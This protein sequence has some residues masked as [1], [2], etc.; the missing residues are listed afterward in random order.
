MPRSS[1]NMQYGQQGYDQQGYGQDGYGQEEG[2]GYDQQGYDQRGYYAQVVWS[3]AKLSG[4]TGLIESRTPL[5]D[6]TTQQ[7]MYMQDVR[8]LPH[9]LHNGEELLLSR[10]NMIKPK[11]TVSRVQCKVQVSADG[12]A[13]LVSC[14]KGP[15]LWRPSGAPWYAVSKSDDKCQLANGDQISLDCNDPDAA[16]FTCQ[17]SSAMQQNYAGQDYSEQQG[18]AQGLPAG[19]TAGIDETSGVTYYYN[20]Q[21]DHSQWEWPSI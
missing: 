7:S 1:T 20:T 2:Y 11:P 12:A 21:T 17:V 15:T 10:W 18:Y 8:L 6:I 19:W 9:A 4:V 16:V 13:A 14:G 5:N 3:V